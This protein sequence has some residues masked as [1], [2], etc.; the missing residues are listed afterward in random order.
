MC[1]IDIL[2]FFVLY[3]S[4]YT[5]PQSIKFDQSIANQIPEL[6]TQPFIAEQGA[7]LPTELSHLN[8]SQYYLYLEFD[9]Y[10]YETIKLLKSTQDRVEILANLKKPLSCYMLF[11]KAIR[12]AATREFSVCYSSTQITKILGSLWKNLSETDKSTW[13]DLAQAIKRLYDP[14]EEF[15]KESRKR[16]RSST[17]E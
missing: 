12:P 13:K 1:A 16:K 14:L 17:D 9:Q 6:S 5:N 3:C 7:N 2:L 10:V 8:E 15:K 4:R 11:C